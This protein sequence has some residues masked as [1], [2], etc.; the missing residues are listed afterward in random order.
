MTYSEKPVLIALS[1]F[2]K[3]LIPQDL[4]RLKNRSTIVN[5]FDIAPRAETY[6]PTT[7]LGLSDFQ[8]LYNVMVP[9]FNE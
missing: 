5:L 9:F 3:G 2:I 8:L 7:V 1:K 4:S 6:K